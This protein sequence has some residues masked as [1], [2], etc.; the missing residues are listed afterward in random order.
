M[1]RYYQSLGWPELAEININQKPW[2]DGPYGREREFVGTLYNNRNMLTTAATARLLHSMVGGV[3]VSGDRSQSML[4]LMNRD[5]KLAQVLPNPGEENQVAGF[6]AAGLPLNSQVY[7]KAGWTSQVRH[8]ACYALMPDR[9]ASVLVVFTEGHAQERQL[10][11][12]IGQQWALALSK[13][14]G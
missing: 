9:S 13:L 12:F 4:N 7:A 6:L 2:S 10:L 1:N 14:Q 3:A 8:D 5:L 11:P